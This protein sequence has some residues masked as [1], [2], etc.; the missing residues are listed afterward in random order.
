[1][2]SIL[3]MMQDLEWNGLGPGN[4][5]KRPKAN[6]LMSVAGLPEG[7]LLLPGM[8]RYSTAQVRPILFTIW[9]ACVMPHILVSAMV[10][11]EAKLDT[12]GIMAKQSWLNLALIVPSLPQNL[13]SW[14]S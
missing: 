13:Y 9:K 10:H 12:I 1:M 3:L 8:A 6:V 7:R 4:L 14:I 5:F 11:Y 2:C